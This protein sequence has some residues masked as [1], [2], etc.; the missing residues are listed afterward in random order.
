[1]KV[2][3][4]FAHPEPQS[5]NGSLF[6]VSINELKAQ[7]HQVQTSDLY[8][9]RWK[10]EIDRADFPNH[11]VDARLMPTYASAEAY[12][13]GNLTDDVK[14]EQEKLL[15]A[16][17]VIFHFP[18][19]WYSMPAILKGWF[20]RVYSLGFA[21]GLGEYNEKH[22]GDRY[23]EGPFVN[24]RAMLV[25]TIGGWEEHYSA[26][27]ITGPIDDVLYPIN[28]GILYYPG[29]QVLPSHLVY[30]AH[31]MDEVAFEKEAEKL[32]EKLRQLE[33][34][35]PIA[36]RPQ[37]GGDYEIPTLTLKPGLGGSTETGFSLHIRNDNET[38]GKA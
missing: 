21:Y 22:F 3:I 19:W 28:H 35:E 38:N 13:S 16:D 1:M 31:R 18:L 24:K 4:V 25:P 17:V 10:S 26:R 33:T 36:Y 12:A 30:R 20:E 9:M 15:W 29:F 7:G 32:R 8:A 5:L 11:P 2:F 14:R 6:Q 34:I 37:N 27:G 23:G